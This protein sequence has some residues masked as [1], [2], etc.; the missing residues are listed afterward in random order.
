MGLGWRGFSCDGF[1][2]FHCGSVTRSGE[3]PEV[4]HVPVI[5]AV[6]SRKSFV[7]QADGSVRNVEGSG[8]G[9]CDREWDKAFHDGGGAEG[10]ENDCDGEVKKTRA[11]ARAPVAMGL[12][13]SWLGGG[14]G[15]GG[16]HGGVVS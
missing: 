10:V 3:S 5:K 14:S 1:R 6:D 9:A 15:L 12:A 16:F 8:E 13:C 4:L 11:E 2:G 7:A